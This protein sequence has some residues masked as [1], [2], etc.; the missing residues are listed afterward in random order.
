MKK[1]QTKSL[2]LHQ[3]QENTNSA[4]LPLLRNALLDGVF[5]QEV[6]VAAGDSVIISHGLKRVPQGWLVMTKDGAGDIWEVR[7]DANFLELET[8]AAAD[9]VFT[10]Y[11]F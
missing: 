6:E 9:L 5:H 4:I 1:I 2:D 10:V 7:G 3:V 11:I 8:D